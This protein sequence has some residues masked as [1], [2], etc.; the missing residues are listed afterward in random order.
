GGGSAGGGSAGGGSAGGGSAGGGS[1]GGGSAGGGSAGGG[2]AGGGSAGGGA[3]GGGSAGGGSG[4]GSQ[5]TFS[6][7]P[8]WLGVTGVVVVGGFGQPNDWKPGNPFL[9]LS[10][11][12]GTYTGTATL[13]DGTYPYLFYVTGD[14]DASGI[15][16]RYVVDPGNKSAMACPA[17]SPTTNGNPDNPCSMLTVPQ[18]IAP[19]RAVS[20]RVLFDGAPVAGYL[21]VLERDE[22]GQHHYFADRLTTGSDGRFTFQ[23]AA[24]MYRVQSQHPTFLSLSD[25]ERNPLVLQAMR[26]SLTG[27]V[28]VRNADV[29]LGSVE[30]SNHVYAA[31]S[32]NDAGTFTLPIDLQFPTLPGAKAQQASVYGTGNDGGAPGIGDPWFNSHNTLATHALWDGGF[33]TSKANEPVARPGE[34]YF[35]GTWYDFPNDAGITWTAQSMVLKLKV[36]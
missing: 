35:W 12:G 4:G 6:Y 29:T 31:M 33:N 16:K 13:P 7:K 1:A 36:P 2:S 3:S 23:A 34:R 9:T 32:P 5:V 20:G 30:M 22:V 10:N 15:T 26:R 8:S 19:T 14:A 17:Q 27:R 24:G 21:V 11:N 28:T 18:V 25:E